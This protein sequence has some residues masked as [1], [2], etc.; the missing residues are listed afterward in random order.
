MAA[1]TFVET[2]SVKAAEN[3]SLSRPSGDLRAEL[4]VLVTGFCYVGPTPRTKNTDMAV[5][6]SD[7]IRRLPEPA[8]IAV[9]L[10]LG[11]VALWFIV[12][13]VFLYA[14]YNA[15]TYDVFWR[16]RFG[17]IP[18]ILGGVVAVPV[19]LTQL[20]LGLTGRIGILHRTLGRIYVAAIA[21]ASVGGF[22]LAVTIDSR[23][24]AYAAGLFC[25]AC[26]WV[27]TTSMALVAVRHRAFEQHR[28][29]MIRSYIV[30]FAFV[31]FRLLDQAMIHWQVAPADEVETF[32]AF[33]CWSVPLLLAEPLIQLRRI[34]NH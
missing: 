27:I 14:S 29:W 13:K 21:V 7:A 18:H 11:A 12:H 33:A 32:M 31:T 16:R 20:W 28:E 19:G 15:P 26:A 23:Y 6:S 5:R 3:P 24:F 17:L 4:I 25:L 22:Y 2:R 9:L 1:S 30:T 34:W 8:L 10:A